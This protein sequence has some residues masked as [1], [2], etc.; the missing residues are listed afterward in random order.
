MKNNA[1]DSYRVYIIKIWPG[2]ALQNK[3]AYKCPLEYTP[4]LTRTRHDL[5]LVF[6]DFQNYANIFIFLRQGIKL[7]I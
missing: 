2:L 4:T 3:L 7:E 1:N 6:T 5:R